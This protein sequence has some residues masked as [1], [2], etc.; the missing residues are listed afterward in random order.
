[1][2]VRSISSVGVVVVGILPTLVG[3][4]AFALLI[5]GLCLLAYRE[6]EGMVA[7]LPAGSA[8][9]P[10]GYWVVG[11]AGVA[12]LA[13][14]STL[15]L[16]GVVLLAVAGPLVVGLFRPDVVPFV[17]WPPVAA[18]SLY[19][20]LPVF[21]AV[22]LRDSVGGV[23]AAWLQQLAEVVAIGWNAQPRGLA[24]TLIVIVAIWCGDAAAY[25]IGR[26]WG[27]TPLLPRISP[28]KTVEGAAAGAAAACLIAVLGLWLFGMG[29]P[30]P[31]GV[32]FG[33]VLSLAGQVGDLAESCLK[34]QVGVKD[35]GALIPGHG[36]MLD[37]LDALLFALPTGWLLV[38]GIERIW[39]SGGGG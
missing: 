8:L 38:G 23:A 10:F 16:T 3:G 1:V 25:L 11:A 36:G 20:A 13:G 27:R 32:G 17:D 37:R 14:H 18:G 26:R 5:A 12:G 30:W 2:R 31:V 34:R 35:S 6:Y 4:P 15:G 39:A 22:A 7:R 19:L 21:A 29:L 33:L 24:W 9:L 28:K